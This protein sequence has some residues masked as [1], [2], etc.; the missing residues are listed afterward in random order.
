MSA[1]IRKKRQLSEFIE[2]LGV[3]RRF[4]ERTI[5]AYQTDLTQLEDYLSKH[6][7]TLLAANPS[8]LKS[9]LAQVHRSVSPRTMCRKLAAI[10][11]FY[12]FV[13]RR[14]WLVQNPSEKIQFPSV[15]SKL[16]IF[17]N[18]EE[19][20]TLLHTPDTRSELGLRD[21]G[22]LELLYATGIRVSELVGL[23]LQDLD[24]EAKNVKVIGKGNKERWVPFGREAQE[25]IRAYLLV[26]KK[27]MIRSRKPET[28]AVWLNRLGGRLSSRSVRRILDRT[29]I[30][31]GLQQQ[32]SPHILR[33]TFATH[34]LQAGADL[35]VIQEL[36]GHASL[37]VT[38]GYTHVE[39]TRLLDVYDRFHPRAHSEKAGAALPQRLSHKKPKGEEQ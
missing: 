36:L 39:M 27:L 7:N 11:S 4:S 13:Q 9:F 32:I 19:V 28:E 26:R 24:L 29:I 38:Q 21:R 15:P 33:H 10:R 22:L 2:Y 20:E 5:R 12:R 3:Q 25:A 37:S 31:A 34:L 18:R 30:R 17:L 35:R 6:N 23:N 14:G 1:P 8:D 16:P